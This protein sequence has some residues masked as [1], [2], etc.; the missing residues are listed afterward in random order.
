MS[1]LMKR[2][3]LVSSAAMLSLL[4]ALYVPLSL[5]GAGHSEHEQHAAEV[6]ASE[7]AGERNAAQAKESAPASQQMDHGSMNHGDLTQGGMDHENM[8]D[9]HGGT[10]AEAGSNHDH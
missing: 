9:K 1:T 2:K 3:A 5:A 7:A 8:M 10:E 6:P 4:A